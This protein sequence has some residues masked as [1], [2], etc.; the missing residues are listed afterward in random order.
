MT[1]RSAP[2]K[3]GFK[4]EAIVHVTREYRE[5]AARTV[6]VF[7]VE[8]TRRMLCIKNKSSRLSSRRL[9]VVVRVDASR[10]PTHD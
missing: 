3:S 1:L 2:T 4:S 8:T 6:F 5:L 9:V 7:V 10:V